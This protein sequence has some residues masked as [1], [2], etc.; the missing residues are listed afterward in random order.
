M[1]W[2]VRAV[3]KQAE[4][5]VKRPWLRVDVGLLVLSRG[6]AREAIAVV[7]PVSGSQVHEAIGGLK[8]RDEGLECLDKAPCG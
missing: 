7:G 5:N 3:G 8:A 6:F 2:N 4:M 1:G